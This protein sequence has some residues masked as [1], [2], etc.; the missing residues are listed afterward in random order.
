MSGG[1][2]GQQSWGT[3]LLNP[4]FTSTSSEGQTLSPYAPGV[5][6]A[7]L[8]YVGRSMGHEWGNLGLLRTMDLKWWKDRCDHH[9][10]PDKS[11]RA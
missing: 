8:S 5:V 9:Q 11:P 3:E 10:E 6:P 2:H 4:S 7:L 1:G